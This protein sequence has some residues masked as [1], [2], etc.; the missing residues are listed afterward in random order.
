[1]SV[2]AYWSIKKGGF[3]K[4]DDVSLEI[5][6]YILT[7]QPP[8]FLD[9]PDIMAA[10]TKIY[11]Q[12]MTDLALKY[13]KVPENV[14]ESWLFA[15]VHYKVGSDPAIVPIPSPGE[16]AYVA[17]LEEKLDLILARLP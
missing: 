1:M 3:P 12:S 8:E 13:H 6:D 2:S 4:P 9:N 16:P 7:A 11:G 5:F 14:S 15:G 10:F 17:R